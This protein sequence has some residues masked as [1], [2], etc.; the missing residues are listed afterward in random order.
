MDE[1]QLRWVHHNHGEPGRRPVA[2]IETRHTRGR[3][4]RE[5]TRRGQPVAA[6]NLV[7]ELLAQRAGSQG[8]EGQLLEVLERLGGP[9]LIGPIRS[10]GVRGGVLELETGDP[11]VLY[12]LRIRWEQRVL[13]SVNIDMPHL[14]IRAVRF[15]L[16][17][18]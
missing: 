2:P 17:R 18:R 1:I 12:D 13:R 8:V 5:Q 16:A 14:G 7:S 15:R 4:R 6:G 3:D 10:V 9:E 11:A